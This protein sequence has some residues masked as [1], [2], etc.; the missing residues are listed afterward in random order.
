MKDILTKTVNKTV[1]D[2]NLKIKRSLKAKINLER[3]IT[4]LQN[5]TNLLDP[6]PKKTRNEQTLKKLRCLL[7]KRIERIEASENQF[8]NAVVL[9]K[10]IHVYKETK[11]EV[12]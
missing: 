6:G 8:N 7:N 4:D 2:N 9:M 10:Q 11:M 1:R 12:A 5:E 3:Q